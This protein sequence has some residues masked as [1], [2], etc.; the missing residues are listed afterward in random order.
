MIEFVKGT[1][2]GQNMSFGGDYEQ[3]THCISIFPHVI[4]GGKTSKDR[5][6]NTQTRKNISASAP[7]CHRLRMARTESV[8]DETCLLGIYRRRGRRKGFG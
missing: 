4:W 2:V 6:I 7:D 8:L 1:I 3:F 5:G